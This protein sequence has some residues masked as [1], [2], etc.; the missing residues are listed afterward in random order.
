VRDGKNLVVPSKRE[1]GSEVD[2]NGGG[3]T[4]CT[5]LLDTKREH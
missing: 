2:V 1:G 4:A 3:R 5:P